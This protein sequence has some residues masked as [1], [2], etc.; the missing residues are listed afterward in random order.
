MSVFHCSAI[1]IQVKVGLVCAGP[2]DALMVLS[3]FLWSVQ[4][5][6]LGRHAK[7]HEQFGLARNQTAMFALL[8]LGWLALVWVTADPG[9]PP[10]GAAL[11][12][13]GLSHL[14][15][16]QSAELTWQMREVFEC[17]A[18]QDRHLTLGIRLIRHPQ[19][20]CS[21]GSRIRK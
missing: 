7:R 9:E 21:L 4:T 16:Q 13:W 17:R 19:A 12:H 14:Q 6:R 8:S 1:L 15:L 20:N 11:S 5:V 10:T 18:K 2:G 3:A